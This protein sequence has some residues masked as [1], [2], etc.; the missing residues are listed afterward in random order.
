MMFYEAQLILQNYLRVSKGLVRGDAKVSIKYAGDLSQL[1]DVARATVQVTDSDSHTLSKL[2]K[3]IKKYVASPR[4]QGFQ[5]LHFDDRYLKPLGKGYRDFLLLIKVQGVV[6]EIQINTQIMLLVKSG[7]GHENYEESRIWNDILI[8]AARKN[9]TSAVIQL[10]AR[11]ADA[12]YA[13]ANGF[14]ALDYASLHGNK[15]MAVALVEQQADVF[16]VDGSGTLP[17]NRA[18]VKEEY[19]VVSILVQHMKSVCS[20]FDQPLVL[21]ATATQNVIE[22]WAVLY[23]VTQQL[24]TTQD[25]GIKAS[26]TKLRREEWLKSRRVTRNGISLQNAMGVLYTDFEVVFDRVIGGIDKL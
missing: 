11:K 20:K 5:V 25:Q 1:T 4:K 3:A 17:V 21:T 18:A 2:Y 22:T 7:G 14:S 24:T 16:R 10:M 6:C 13:T 19:D 8:D 26:G 9:D 15:E 23:R 12:C